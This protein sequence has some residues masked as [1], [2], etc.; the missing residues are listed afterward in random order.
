MT[1]FKAGLKVFTVSQVGDLPLFLFTF[2]L[3]ARTGSSD[4]GEII[5]LLPLI[6]F[7]YLS[8]TLFGFST[9]LHLTTVLGLLL[10]VA[11]CL[12]AAQ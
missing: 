9:C 6:S 12:K 1:S 11:V 4:C 8:L 5:G 3:L 10:Q 2:L 7:D